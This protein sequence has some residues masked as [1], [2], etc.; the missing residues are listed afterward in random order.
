M[1]A[2]DGRY[3]MNLLQTLEAE[4]TAKLVAARPVPRFQ[5]GDSVRVVSFDRRPRTLSEWTTSKETL[6]AALEK[7]EA[8]GERP[9]RNFPSGLVC[10]EPGPVNQAQP[11]P[12]NFPAHW[13]GPRDS[14][15]LLPLSPPSRTSIHSSLGRSPPR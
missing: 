7:V 14:P 5:P 13:P 11:V 2:A 4:Q 8:A 1:P 12:K 15:S 3:D 6:L 10:A 9:P